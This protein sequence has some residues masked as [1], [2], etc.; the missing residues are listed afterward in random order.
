MR[1][2]R[3]R[4]RFARDHL[5]AA[6]AAPPVIERP[7]AYQVSYGLVEG[8][9][10]P[11]ATPRGRPRRRPRRRA[12]R[13]P[14]REPSS[15]TSSCRRARSA[16]GSRP[17]TRAAGAPG[18]TVHHVFGLPRAAR[19]RVRLP[20]LDPAA[21]AGRPAARRRVPRDRGRVRREP[22][23]RGRS[24]MERASDVPGRLDPQAR[25]RGHAADAHR[26]PAACRE[27]GLDGLVRRHADRVGQRGREPAPA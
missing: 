1:H 16:S 12:I 11:G 19:P 10:A 17:S 6:T 24:R 27:A 14:R 3:T 23:H 20:S 15:S 5:A 2:E 22:R 13:A 21:A 8:R 7:A 9:A 26:R 4:L 25:D 18:R